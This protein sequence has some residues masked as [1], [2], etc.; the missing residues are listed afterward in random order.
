M[1]TTANTNEMTTLSGE[2][3]LRCPA[4]QAV[5]V[6]LTSGQVSPGPDQSLI[7]F[8]AFHYHAINGRPTAWSVYRSSN[9]TTGSNRI[10]PFRFDAADVLTV[11]SVSWS[12]STFEVTISVTGNYYVYISGA[13]QPNRALGMTL[14]R[15][16]VDVF[17]V[18]RSATNGDGV[19]TLGHGGVIYLTPGDRLK[20]IGEPN[21]AGYSGPAERHASFFGFLVV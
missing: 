15:N 14:Q 13:T 1:R 16:G 9:W 3:L 19:E 10:D 21:T 6:E 7:S 12:G 2:F 4:G 17:G 8:T 5:T 18:Y 11:G 20:V